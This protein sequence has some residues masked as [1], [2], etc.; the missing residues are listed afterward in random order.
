MHNTKNNLDMFIPIF[1]IAAF[2]IAALIGAKILGKTFKAV[3]NISPQN[4]SYAPYS[5]NNLD[6]FKGDNTSNITSEQGNVNLEGDQTFYASS[7][8]KTFPQFTKI[9]FKPY[10]VKNN[11]TQS[12]IVSVKDPSGVKSIT[13]AILD[14]SNQQVP[15]VFN[16]LNKTD[17]DGEYWQGTWQVYGVG[18]STHYPIELHAVSKSDNHI[19]KMTAFFRAKQS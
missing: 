18:S 11:M 6:T 1:V 10:T 4:Q 2:F 12:I 15:I 19:E 17:G 13:A 8:A 16:K 14:D 3:F 5:S 7:G 9:E